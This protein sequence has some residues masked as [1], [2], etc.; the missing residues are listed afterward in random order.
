MYFIL[1]IAIPIELAQIQF[2][3]K[4]GMCLRNQKLVVPYLP[5]INFELVY[6]FFHLHNNLIM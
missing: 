6:D 4:I 1:S 5:L 3:G 2:T